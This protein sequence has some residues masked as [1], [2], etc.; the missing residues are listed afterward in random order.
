M[1]PPKEVATL[2]LVSETD[3]A[4]D[5]VTISGM[6]TYDT[7]PTFEAF[8][9]GLSINELTALV[10][11]IEVTFMSSTGWKLI[12]RLLK[13]LKSQNCPHQL[14]ISQRKIRKTFADDLGFSEL[15]SPFAK[16]DKAIEA[17][18]QEVG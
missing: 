13:N 6:L 12:L 18:K 14:V 2:E 11:V 3:G 16:T 5:I 17:T 4:I 1:T 10:I 8:V 9:E 7:A 15:I